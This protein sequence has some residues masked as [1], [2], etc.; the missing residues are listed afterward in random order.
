M[1]REQSKDSVSMSRIILW[2]FSFSLETHQKP[3]CGPIVGPSES[4]SMVPS[5]YLARAAVPDNLI[6]D[7]LGNLQCGRSADV[8][9][10]QEAPFVFR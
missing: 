5:E 8:P 6:T 9:S 1:G 7:G 10:N 3:R 2:S 4:H